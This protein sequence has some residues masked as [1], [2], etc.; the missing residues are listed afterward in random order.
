MISVKSYIE[1]QSCTIT[2]IAVCKCMGFL[3]NHLPYVFQYIDFNI[4]K[5]NNLCHNL[6]N[7]EKEDSF[8]SFS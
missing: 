1:K 8:E 7:T 5:S 3:T 2:G 4:A 6:L